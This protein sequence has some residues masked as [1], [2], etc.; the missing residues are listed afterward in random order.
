MV[1][2]SF[3]TEC[4]FLPYG[5]ASLRHRDPPPM[6]PITSQPHRP[7]P[8]QVSRDTDFSLSPIPRKLC[9]PPPP[10]ICEHLHLLTPN[11]LEL[12]QGQLGHLTNAG[13]VWIPGVLLSALGGLS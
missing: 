11:L 5:T 1:A 12:L 9:D 7:S 2:S 10:A 4:G 6:N 13:A 3:P 8:G